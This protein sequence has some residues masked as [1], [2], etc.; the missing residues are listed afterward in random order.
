MSRGNP[1]DYEEHSITIKVDTE[2]YCL[3]KHYAIDHG[4]NS[5]QKA[6]KMI[7]QEFFEKRKA[8]RK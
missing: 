3:I 2:L 4:N 1:F 5:A 8:E 6:T 7:V